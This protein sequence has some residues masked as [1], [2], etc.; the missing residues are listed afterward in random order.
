MR[1]LLGML[2]CAGVL[3]AGPAVAGGAPAGLLD[4]TVTM[5][6]STSGTGK[7]ADGTSVSF[8][9]VNTRIVYISSAGRPFLRAEVRGGRATREGELAPGEGGG[10][11]SVSFQGDKLIGTEAFASGA[12]RYIA[13]FDSSFAGCS[14]SVI[15]AKEGSAQIRRRGPDGAMYEITS[16]STGS[17]T[18]SIQTGNIFAH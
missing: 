2:G 9:N 13:S 5:S 11:R 3:F 7:R 17:P 18:C 15:D 1:H 8:S 12:R 16:V 6:W 10:S 14:L 4:K